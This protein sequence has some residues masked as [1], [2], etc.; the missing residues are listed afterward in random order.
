M[1]IELVAA[2][3]AVELRAPLAPASM[4]GTVISSLR[5][6]VMGMG[7]DRELSGELEASNQFLKNGF[8]W[9]AAH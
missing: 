3:R 7:P 5:E 1:A 6:Q 4:T 2:A 9:K 8:S